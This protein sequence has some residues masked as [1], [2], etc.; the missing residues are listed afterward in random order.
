MENKPIEDKPIQDAAE[1]FFK[2]L[3]EQIPLTLLALQAYEN[4]MKKILYE[5][6]GKGKEGDEEFYRLQQTEEIVQATDKAL[7][8][9]H[10]LMPIIEHIRKYDKLWRA[11]YK[12]LKIVSEILPGCGPSF[13][14]KC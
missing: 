8:E 7:F 2:L 5:T 10:N 6:R 1:H 14:C 4:Y 9:F 11:T 12:E 13:R 3:H